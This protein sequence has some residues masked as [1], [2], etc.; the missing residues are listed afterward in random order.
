MNIS[1]V[2]L[3]INKKKLSFFFNFYLSG[4]ID[5][6][7]SQRLFMGIKNKNLYTWTGQN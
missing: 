5:R 1:N 7:N 3:K 2:K 6:I 4:L